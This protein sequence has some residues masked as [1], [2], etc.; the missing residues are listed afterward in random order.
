M[1]EKRVV[2]TG[3]GIVSCLGDDVDQFYEKL[4]QGQSGIVP[5]TGFPV[6]A[7]PTRFA[8]E[9]QN[10]DPGAYIDKKQARRIDR[11]IA[12]TLVA[13]K[14]ALE[15][16]GIDWR[17][18]KLDLSRAGVLVGSGI[19]GM[20]AFSDGVGVLNAQGHRRLTPFFVPYILT[21]MA[22]A[23]L[24]QEIGFTG[25]NYSVSTAC[26]TANYA[27]TLAAEHIKRGEADVM[28]VG[29]VEAPISPIGM[30]G[31]SACKALSQRN[32][33]CQ[34]ASRPWD[35]QRD[36]FVMGEGAGIII[37]ESLEH[38][39][40]RSARVLAEFLSGAFSTDAYHLTDPRPDGLGVVRCI[41]TALAK[42]NLKPSDVNYINPHAT[43]TPVGDMA[44]INAINQVFQNR[45]EIAL[46]ATK[47]MIGHSL[48]AASGMEAIVAIKA[49]LTQK[50]HPTINLEDPEPL[51]FFVPT[52]ACDF[53]VDVAISNSFGFGG[54]NSTV[55]F[56]KFP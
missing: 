5:I 47:S 52:Q 34:R 31:F 53:K 28:I 21:N 56:K 54:H 27:I 29:G 44:E 19:G 16:S 23:I 12:Y 42:G 14:K 13:G 35:K 48:G 25:P 51:D 18:P 22:G 8:G 41:E 24:S 30:A 49:L 6:D 7:F 11:F 45:S 32:E 1:K 46:N 10:F 43:S 15:S 20:N 3:M 39:E 26:A 55:V 50:I 4:L 2:V 38:A 33:D 17:D 36:G 37:L 9:I 40:K